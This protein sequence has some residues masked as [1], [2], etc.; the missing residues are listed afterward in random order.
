[1]SDYKPTEHDGL[2]KDGQPDGRV[3]TGQFAQGKVDPVEAGKEGG[4]TGGSAGGQASGGSH[5]SSG[6]GQFAGGKVDPV[7]AGKKGGQ[8]S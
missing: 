1:M 2:R 4:V 6:K 3:G 5:D 8:S 7:E